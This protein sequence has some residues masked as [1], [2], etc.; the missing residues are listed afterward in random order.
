[1]S[2]TGLCESGTSQVITQD[3]ILPV[4]LDSGGKSR[5][6]TLPLGD[7]IAG[8]AKAGTLAG[9]ALRIRFG[10]TAP[11]DLVEVRLNGE[12]IVATWAPGDGA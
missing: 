1:M 2:E 5:Q 11:D 12:P 6:V 4:E 7:D 8:A 9:A 3:Q 10:G